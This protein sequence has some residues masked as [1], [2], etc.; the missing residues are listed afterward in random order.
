M[1]LKR[2]V[3]A[4]IGSSIAVLALLAG[5]SSAQAY[6]AAPATFEGL[7]DGPNYHWRTDIQAQV[8]AQHLGPVLHRVPGSWFNAPDIPAEAKAH[9]GAGQALFGP[10]TPLFI[11]NE[12]MCTLAVA[13]YDMH[14]NKVGIT[15]GHCGAVGAEVFS[16]DAPNAGVAGHVVQVAPD[17]DFAVVQFNQTAQLT[18]S[19]NGVT[20][21]AV[22][23]QPAFGQQVCKKGV[24]T[25]YTCGV[26]WDAY[27]SQV[28]A[29]Q[30]DSGAPMFQG[31]RLIGVISG[32]NPIVPAG[33]C[34]NPWQGPLHMPTLASPIDRILERLNSQGGTGAG[35][36]LA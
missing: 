3:R 8:M 34:T 13:G 7:V 16:A 6:E 33:P 27:N 14:G 32:G 5:T 21:N 24:A 11:S 28:C 29:M 12:K 9:E 10:G 20:I 35:F 4:L 15:A 19:Y 2:P 22:G 23:G 18:R 17:L 25:G 26:A 1:S 36:Y 31:D 30:G